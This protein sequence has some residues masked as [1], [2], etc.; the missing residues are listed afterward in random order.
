MVEPD[1]SF[2]VTRLEGRMD[3]LE[4]NSLKS[5]GGDGTFDGMEARVARLESDVSHI[6]TT[7]ADIK[8]DIRE[9]RAL[10]LAG[11]TGSFFVL[12]GMLVFGYFLLSDLIT[13]HL[14]H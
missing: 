14:I 5:N 2:R 6:K 4:S 9:L 13:T 11:L 10:M 1:Q 8:I 3:N 7:L 12:G